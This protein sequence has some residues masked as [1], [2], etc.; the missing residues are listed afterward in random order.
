M[1]LDFLTVHATENSNDVPSS[2][3]VIETGTPE[4]TPIEESFDPF[5][6]VG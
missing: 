3:N 4:I 5:S 6:S 2:A 1:E